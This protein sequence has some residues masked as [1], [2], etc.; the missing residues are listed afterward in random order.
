MKRLTD[1]ALRAALAKTKTTRI[2]LTDGAV[3]GLSIRIGPG[4]ATW[5]LLLRVTGAGGVSP[6]GHRKTGRRI[7]IS[8]GEYPV[9]TL[10]A[11]RAQA[12][13]YIDQAKRGFSPAV[14]LEKAAT[15]GGL[16]IEALATKFLE[17]YV[18]MKG[19]RA[20]LKYEGA[21]RVHI[22]PRIGEVI[23]D[24]LQREQ[25]RELVKSVM[26]RVPRGKGGRERPRGGK[27]AARTV[28]GV[29][30]KMINWGMRE[31]LLTRST[32]PATGMEDN[33]PKKRRKERVL[34]VDEARIVW[35]AAGTLGYPFG[36]VYQLI[37]LTG[38]RPGE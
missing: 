20:V 35:T 11:A 3:S 37:L 9:M 28:L 13:V 15:A 34:S 21:I 29:L 30:R 14:A 33:L 25:V 4:A 31:E 7:R 8:L 18:K 27:E 38:C 2:E 5:S 17:D 12:N 19:L 1:V 32:N 36:P 22:V 23:A 6:R 16:T 26:V 10:E 24:L